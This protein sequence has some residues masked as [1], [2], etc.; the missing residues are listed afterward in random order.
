MKLLPD[1]SVL[2]EGI[3]S[4]QIADGSLS[5]AQVI[6]HEAVVAE[7]EHQGNSNKQIVGN[8]RR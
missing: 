2:I 4:K 1:T 7:L 3:V 5:P 8:S 6:I